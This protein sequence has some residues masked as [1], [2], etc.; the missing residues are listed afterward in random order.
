MIVVRC[1]DPFL[2]HALALAA[3]AEED[4]VA[5][6]DLAAEALQWRFAR[7]LVRAGGY[8]GTQA[9]EGTPV[10]DLDDAT[11]RRW[12]SE[13]RAEDVHQPKLDF[14]VRRLSGLIEPSA[15]DATWVDTALADL[16]RAAGARLPIS[17]RSFARRVLEFPTRYTSL[18]A[19]AEGCQ[20]SRGALKARFRRR[21]LASPHVYLRWLRLMAAAQVLSDR[22]VTVASAAHR[23]GFTSSGNLCRTMAALAQLTPTE[24]RTVRGWNRLLITFAWAHLTPAALDAWAQVPPLFQR[25]VA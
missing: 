16:S 5:E 13:R 3:H 19:V 11:L 15:A 7:L 23:L 2:R 12:E 20:L 1:T 18:H 24:V 9:P 8:L 6:A 22:S 17:L 14:L 25:R 4:V 21:G 10:L